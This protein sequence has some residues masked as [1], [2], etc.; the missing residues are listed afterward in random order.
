MTQEKLGKLEEV[1]LRDIWESE[2]SDFTPWL[3][4]EENIQIL[5]DSIA[6]DLEVEAQEK[7]VGPFRA[8]ILC[9][10]TE[11]GN[12]VL[13]E[14][15][16]NRTDHPHLGQ[17]LTYAAGLDAVTVVWVAATFTEEHR[18][19]L[20]WLNEITD[21]R[22]RFFGLEIELWRINNS[23]PAPK[24]NIVSKPNDWRRSVIQS[25][26]R[27]NDRRPSLNFQ[28]MG[29]SV[30]S[31]LNSVSGNEIAT[32]LNDRKVKFREQEMSLTKATQMVR[33]INY[34]VGPCPYWK[35]EGRKLSEIYD[36]TYLY[37]DQ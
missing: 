18:A 3:A 4:R 1:E 14:N 5:G 29:I 36:E 31:V 37:D 32:V 21:D 11:N 7:N 22:F 19:A 13:I 27:I 33:E 17:L 2:S 10:D 30:G 9:K 15:Q 26:K 8:D 25:A 16:L 20:D 35:F 28:E 23:P 6:V 12:W 34:S 24:F